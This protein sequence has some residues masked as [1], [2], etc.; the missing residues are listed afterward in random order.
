M[1]L[2]LLLFWVVCMHGWLEA[3]MILGTESH[4]HAT[5]SD[6]TSCVAVQLACTQGSRH[7]SSWTHHGLCTPGNSAPGETGAAVSDRVSPEAMPAQHITWLWLLHAQG[8][9]RPEPALQ[10]QQ[11]SS[12][13][14]ISFDTSLL[15]QLQSR[16]GIKMRVCCQASL[17]V[18]AS[19][20]ATH[21]I[22]VMPEPLTE[23]CAGVQ[24]GISDRGVG[25]CWHHLHPPPIR[26]VKSRPRLRASLLDV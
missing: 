6:C 14:L 23:A 12:M 10:Q 16:L 4:E 8:A 5:S 19:Q 13:S 15:A 20:L 24:A 26:G 9:S 2:L 18:T 25:L 7:R 21:G 1:L 3:E 17:Q 22:P 11:T